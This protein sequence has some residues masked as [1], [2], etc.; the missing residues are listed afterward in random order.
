[1]GGLLDLL[2]PPR[3]GGCRRLGTWFCDSCRAK[4]RPPE[5]PLCRRCGREL[6]FV[7]E[8]CGCSRKLRSVGRIV[9]AAIYDGPL[10]R[11]LHR[12]KYEGWRSL[13]PAL[14][15]LLAERLA[16][17]ALPAA[18]ALAVPLHAERLKQRG[19]NQSELLLR[20]L[21]LPAPAG[22]LERVR[23]TPPQVGQ[24]R[25]HRLANVRDAFRWTGPTLGG[26]PVIVVDDVT[27]TGATLD[28]CAA[29][30]TDSGAGFV[31]GVTLAR[32]RL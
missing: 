24:D 9:A 13:G 31:I 15:D 18:R 12:L 2:L 21:R 22:R 16:A 14:G 3:C 10:E 4:V 7:N 5:P 30:L 28:A 8:G 25:L 26:Q 6:A 11:A 17:E 1:M 23:D 32:V 27:T 29:G 19:F 20:R